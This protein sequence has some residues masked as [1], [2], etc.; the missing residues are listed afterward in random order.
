M[1]ELSWRGGTGG[2]ERGSK[3]SKKKK[4][5]EKKKE[6][7]KQKSGTVGGWLSVGKIRLKTLTE[8]VKRRQ[9]WLMRVSRP[10][11]RRCV[12]T[13]WAESGKKIQNLID[14]SW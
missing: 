8:S 13:T 9:R 6:K 12:V 3:K 4:E 5:K 10:K 1:S 14:I 11:R 7:K 2:R